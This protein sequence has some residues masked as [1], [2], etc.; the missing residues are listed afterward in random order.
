[1]W[2]KELHQSGTNTDDVLY[3]GKGNEVIDG[4]GGNDV[5]V[6]RTYYTDS[7]LTFDSTKGHWTLN[8]SSG[9]PLALINIERILFADIEIS[10]NDLLLAQPTQHQSTEGTDHMIGSDLGY[11]FNSGSGDDLLTGN[12]GDDT[13]YGGKGTDL[14]IY[15]GSSSD[16]I[17]ERDGTTGMYTIKDLT[18]DRDGT[19]TLGSIERLLF[20]DGE[21]DI[22][23]L[24]TLKPGSEPPPPPPQDGNTAIWF[25]DGDSIVNSTDGGQVGQ[26]AN[27]AL[28]FIGI[29]PATSGLNTGFDISL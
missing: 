5:L 24:A 4:R 18:V 15:R 25:V 21:F 23:A 17:V 28:E 1:M 13:L 9:K 11:I 27:V 8:F 19:D 7:G 16:Y 3:V 22:N 10:L 2:K 26:V 29:S 14:A 6:I 12:G 20:A